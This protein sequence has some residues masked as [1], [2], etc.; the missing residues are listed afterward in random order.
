M[1]G[2][3]TVTDVKVLRPIF[4]ATGRI[5]SAVLQH[6]R[7]I[8]PREPQRGRE[9]ARERVKTLLTALPRAALHPRAHFLTLH[10]LSLSL[11]RL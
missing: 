7:Y 11:S 1:A 3:R 9:V 2:V 6:P 5:K 8:R 4:Q 10:P